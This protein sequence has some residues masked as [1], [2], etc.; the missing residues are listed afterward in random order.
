MFNDT[1]G[2]AAE[3]STAVLRVAHGSNGILGDL[4]RY[5]N[6]VISGY[7]SMFR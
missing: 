6:F 1:V 7:T 5:F 2:S 4:E 3:W